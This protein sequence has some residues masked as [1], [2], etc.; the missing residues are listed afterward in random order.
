MS[1][2]KVSFMQRI[3]KS[4]LPSLIVLLL[5]LHHITGWSQ[6]AEIDSLKVLVK[7]QSSD[8]AKVRVLYNL[9][10]QLFGHSLDS[11][12]IYAQECYRIGKD[13][14]DP[15]MRCSSL[16]IM[17]TCY[18]YM[19]EYDS[20]EYYYNQALEI[21]KQH[22]I[23]D[24]ASA[25]YTNMGVLY[26][27][28]GKFDKAIEQYLEGLAVDDVNDQY[29]GGVIKR[30]N[31]A[32]LY[33]SQGDLEGGIRYSEEALDLIPLVEHEAKDR[34]HSLL[35]NN[36]GTIYLQDSMWD[37]AL[38]YFD[39]SLVI[40]RQINNQNEIARNL[41]NIGT[42][43][44]KIGE[45]RQ[46]LPLL[47]D[48][49]QIRER[50]DD[51][52]GL[53]ETHMELG[54]TYSKMNDNATSQV[55]FDRAIQIAEEI[56]DLSLLSET[57]RAQSDE[58]NRLGNHDLALNALKKSITYH[59]SLQ[60]QI[61][62][63]TKIEMEAKYQTARKDAQLAA[64]DLLISKR[65][66]QRNMYIAAGTLL[67]LGLFYLFDRNKKNKKLS[68]EKLDNLKKYQKIL[69]MDAM[70][71]GQ[72]DERKR[73]AQDLHD[74]L[75]SLLAAARLQMHTIQREIE[76]M[77]ELQL[78]G[79]T[80]KLIDTAC[81][82]VRRISHDMMPSVLLEH[83]FL[84]AIKDLVEELKTE[85]GLLIRY[86]IKG[87]PDLDD[88]T[89]LNVY[90]IIQEILQ[91]AVK[92]AH[93]NIIELDI[94]SMS[95]LLAISITDDGVGFDPTRIQSDGIGLKNIRSRVNYLNGKL[96]FDSHDQKGCMYK[97]QIPLSKLE[98][99]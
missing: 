72:E 37:K 82:E 70:L 9:T 89:T 75:G 22:H 93:A 85:H 45:A 1:W 92:H 40:N 66:N 31:I 95:E 43:K 97:I 20:S 29:Y 98:E 61:D 44:E 88:A 94:E 71:Q 53:I 81:D 46:G 76:K 90:R 6:T 57:Y 96:S 77:G 79:K 17:G 38:Y 21:T 60:Q 48:A 18:L 25:L 54:T 80:E 23:P 65:T 47:L 35:L 67:L 2:I 39:E 13:V 59:D 10:Y 19:N 24:K 3:S 30:I 78:V 27:R 84:E 87:N 32:N 41:H 83:G 33:S 52:V 12:L 7:E 69:A 34:M 5:S 14:E 42:L 68:E 49:L 28:Q 56:D 63:Q 16:S 86:D 64:S 58:Y 99:A 26:K 74:G 73:I 11:A 36:L 62:Q 51:R 91:N 8:T 55:H 15:G 4:I 50:V